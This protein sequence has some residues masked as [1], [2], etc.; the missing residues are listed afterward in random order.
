MT[1]NSKQENG[2]LVNN[3]KRAFSR[4]YVKTEVTCR[5]FAGRI[6]VRTSDGILRNF[7]ADGAYIESSDPYVP[8]SIIVLNMIHFPSLPLYLTEEIS[9]R[10]SCLAEV[11]WKQELTDFE[12]FR[13]GVGLRYLD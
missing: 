10:S 3:E 11:R 4:I 5:S 2:I 12:V 1:P 8:G 13:Y 6:D 9:P 7:S